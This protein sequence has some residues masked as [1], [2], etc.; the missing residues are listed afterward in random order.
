MN[1]Y[2]G[3]KAIAMTIT[4]AATAPPIPAKIKTRLKLFAFGFLLVP[5]AI[6]L[7][8]LDPIALPIQSIGAAKIKY[9]S[10]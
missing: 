2:Y 4:S 3:I 5:Q 9:Q 6:E 1:M 10:P 7:A 8:C